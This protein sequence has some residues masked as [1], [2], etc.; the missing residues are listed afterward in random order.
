MAER[1]ADPILDLKE[2][3]TGLS[4]RE[5]IVR[6][7]FGLVAVGA[8]GCSSHTSEAA[9]DTRTSLPDRVY[10]VMSLASQKEVIA[11]GIANHVVGK[12]PNQDCP[13]AIRAVP[14]RYLMELFPRENTYT[15][16]LNGWIFGIATSGVPFDPTGPFWSTTPG[17]TWQFEVMSTVARPYLG[18]DGNNAHVQPN[19]EYHYH[20]IPYGLVSTLLRENV[21]RAPLLLGW[22]AD[23]FPIYGPWGYTDPMDPISPVRLVRPGYQ[24]KTGARP[25]DAPK[26]YFDGTFVEDYA[27]VT[28]SG[29]IDECNGRFGIVPDYPGGTYHYYLTASFP[30]IPRLYRGTPDISFTHPLPGPDAIPPALQNIG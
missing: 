16:P 1:N 15:I 9:A 22:A 5:F 12:F 3:S 6:A 7:G 20:G 28:G 29:D 24:L 25:L 18:L 17:N 21:G 23:G 30:F 4:R 13:I 11:N 14:A 8:A 2:T 10:I 27:F 26:G 19:G